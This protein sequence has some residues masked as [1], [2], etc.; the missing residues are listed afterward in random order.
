VSEVEDYIEEYLSFR[1]YPSLTP[2]VRDRTSVRSSAA[3]TLSDLTQAPATPPLKS[4]LADFGEAF[5]T[6]NHVDLFLLWQNHVPRPLLRLNSTHPSAAAAMSLEFYLNLHCACY[7]FRDEY[8]QTC[9]SLEELTEACGKAMSVFRR[10]IESR[11]AGL[12]QT[13][14]FIAFYALPYVPSPT[15]H[16]T[17]VPLFRPSW[18]SSLRGKLLSFV[19][20]HV[21][22][23][24]PRAP[25]IFAAV[26]EHMAAPTPRPDE[27]KVSGGASSSARELAVSDFAG[28]VLG[29]SLAL[30]ERVSKTEGMKDLEVEKQLRGF[31]RTMERLKKE[32]GRGEGG[33]GRGRSRSRSPSQGPSQGPSSRAQEKSSG[34]RSVSPRNPRDVVGKMSSLAQ[35]DLPLLAGDLE[36]LATSDKPGDAER[37]ALIVQA[38]RWRFTRAPSLTLLSG[39]RRASERSREASGRAK[40]ERA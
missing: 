6:A 27:K 23:P 25:R 12:S 32:Q 35:L 24:A 13:P 38:L 3:Q 18:L 5:D 15:E 8:M 10:Y 19:S 17:F 4:V 34:R 7:P 20:A 37:A 2:F 28:S 29:L 9:S 39:V 36:A 21:S 26:A 22:V 40:S 11:G 31:Q 30:F 14:E 33:G 16:P 1:S